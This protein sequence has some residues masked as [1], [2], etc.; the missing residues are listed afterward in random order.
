MGDNFGLVVGAINMVTNGS[1]HSVGWALWICQPMQGPGST[2]VANCTEDDV[3]FY[4]CHFW[5]N[6]KQKMY[7][8]RFCS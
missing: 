2:V 6:V 5:V 8:T 4:Y 3:Y 7:N 1:L